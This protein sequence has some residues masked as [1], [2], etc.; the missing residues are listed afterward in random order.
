LPLEPEQ[1]KESVE[2]EVVDANALPAVP[3]EA[4]TDSP[5]EGSTEDIWG[6][7][8]A[9]GESEAASQAEHAHEN[10]VPEASAGVPDRASAAGEVG[11]R[12]GGAS[13]SEP[14]GSD[15]GAALEAEADLTPE[16]HDEAPPDAGARS[17]VELEAAPN[18][19]APGALE[20]EAAESCEGQA[21]TSSGLASSA[22]A[23]FLG[24][25]I[26]RHWLMGLGASKKP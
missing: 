14:D 21:H 5:T 15:G 4:V 17:A 12:S 3:A 24:I 8:T 13:T 23:P 7:G 2:D 11:G 16:A 9:M 19:E 1:P 25:Q 22:H 18:P 20:V 10:G 6:T 26:R